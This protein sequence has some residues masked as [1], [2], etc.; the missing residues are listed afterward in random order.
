MT[1]LS[2]QGVASEVAINAALLIFIVSTVLPG[3]VG[4]LLV[5]R[6][7]LRRSDNS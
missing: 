4:A 1:V 5:L 7:S 2:S 3:A 6:I